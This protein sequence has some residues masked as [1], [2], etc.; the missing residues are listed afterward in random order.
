MYISSPAVNKALVSCQMNYGPKFD[1]NS[2]AGSP[3]LQ[4]TCFSISWYRN[5]TGII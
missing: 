2:T 3:C 5:R 4:H 1:A